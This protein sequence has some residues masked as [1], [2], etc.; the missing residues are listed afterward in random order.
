MRA[1]NLHVSEL[2]FSPLEVRGESEDQ[3]L[4]GL[5]ISEH[6]LTVL[7]GFAVLAEVPEGGAGTERPRDADRTCTGRK[8]LFK[9]PCHP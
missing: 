6:G 7:L 1:S 4:E 3:K 5:T 2:Q 8:G 9:Q